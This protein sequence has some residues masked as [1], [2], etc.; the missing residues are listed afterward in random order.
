[1]LEKGQ[2][3]L[4]SS[5]AIDPIDKE[6]SKG[7]KKH[8]FSLGNRGSPGRKFAPKSSSAKEQGRTGRE[9]LQIWDRDLK[10]VCKRGS[11]NV[12]DLQEAETMVIAVEKRKIFD[13]PAMGL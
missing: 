3:G 1:M 5:K 7:R 13:I 10:I 12:V 2:L 4:F 6:T 11:Y 9:S 8:E